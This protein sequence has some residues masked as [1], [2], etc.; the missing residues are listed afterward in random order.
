MGNIGVALKRFL[1][2]KNTVTIIGIVL[3]IV[4]LYIGYNMRVKQA[5]NPVKVPYAKE[6][7][8]SR[9]LI[10]EDMIGFIDVPRSMVNAT[11]NLLTN[12]S[13]V[14][15]KYARYG[16]TIPKNSLFYK[17]AVMTE[18]EKPDSAFANIPDDSTV[19][20]L[21]VDL[22]TTYGNSIFPGNYIDLYF[23]AIDDTGKIIFGKFIESIEVLAV[24]D[25]QGNHVFETTVESRTPSELL[26]AV[27]NDMYDLLMKAKYITGRAIDIIPVPRNAAYTADPGDTSVSNEYIRDFILSK[28][29]V[30]PDNITE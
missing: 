18:E 11:D 15:D 4:V 25:N 20:S 23:S 17:E 14:V 19:Y 2:N 6:E 9:T 21:G 1:S 24:K 16:T 3:G 8:A 22:H 10:T 26:F 7:I 5:I 29:A 28:S 13:L 12:I 27:K 30:I